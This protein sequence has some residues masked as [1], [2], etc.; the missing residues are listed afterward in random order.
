MYWFG[1]PAQQ[2]LALEGQ[3]WYQRLQPYTKS[4]W[5]TT[6]SDRGTFLVT[7]NKPVLECP[8]YDRLPGYYD[9]MH[10][11]YGCNGA[12]VK[13]SGLINLGSQASYGSDLA[14]NVP[15]G[16]LTWDPRVKPSMVVQPS[17]MIA[18]GDSEIIG[19]ISGWTNL[20]SSAP[21]HAW[22]GLYEL[23]S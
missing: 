14:V 19:Y 21:F 1:L 6:G 16:G 20:A 7:T 15:A 22:N 4:Q 10:G 17:D 3:H 8:A 9:D 13:N 5:P 2:L 18:M 12:G 11:S 23:W